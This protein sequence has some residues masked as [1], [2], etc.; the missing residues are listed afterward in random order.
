MNIKNKFKKV[1]QANILKSIFLSK[2]YSK[3]FKLLNVCDLIIKRRWQQ[4]IEALHHT[5]TRMN[6]QGDFGGPIVSF[7]KNDVATIRGIV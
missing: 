5:L 6:L 3:F 4:S 7:N 1:F 2:I